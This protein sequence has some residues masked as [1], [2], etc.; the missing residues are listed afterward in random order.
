MDVHTSEQRSRNMAAI[1]AGNTG[2]EMRVRSLL[3]S[4]GYRYRL[5]RKELPGK[6][7]VVLV[8]HRTVIFVHGCF[9]HCHECRWGRVIPKTRPEFWSKKRAGNVGRDVRHK[10]ALEQAGWK[11]ITI[12]ECETR[13]QDEIRRVLNQA[14]LRMAK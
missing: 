7:D 1:K 2:P 11:V 3:H 10:A 8:K 5:H 13:S 4:L 12:W 14:G 6:P 9:W